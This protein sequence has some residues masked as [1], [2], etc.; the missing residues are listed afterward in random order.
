[1]ESLQ[2]ALKLLSEAG[3]HLR[4]LLLSSKSAWIHRFRFRRI[5]LD[6]Q[7]GSTNFS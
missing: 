6:Q 7:S 1:M 4:F 2:F 3:E 5:I